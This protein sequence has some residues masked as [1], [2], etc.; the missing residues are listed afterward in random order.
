MERPDYSVP[1]VIPSVGYHL[2]P[3]FPTFRD[4]V[5]NAF[6]FVH[7]TIERANTRLQRRGART[8]WVTPRHFLDFIQHFVNLIREKRSDLEEQQLHLNVGLQKIMETVEQV[9]FGSVLIVFKLS[10]QCVLRFHV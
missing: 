8:M 7:Q 3:E 6:V 1:D 2:L 5:S 9:S 4:M 10:C